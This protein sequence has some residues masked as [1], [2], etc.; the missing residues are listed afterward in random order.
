MTAQA[1]TVDVSIHRGGASINGAPL[2]TS[3]PASEF[4]AIFGTPDRI[5]DGSPTP[6][7]VGH[8]NNQFHYYDA[9]GVTLNEH[10]YTYQMQHAFHGE[11]NVG[12]LH[13]VIG[14][15]E[16]QLSDADLEFTA[17]LPGTWFTTIPSSVD[18]QTITVAVSTQGPK[19]KSGRSSKTKVITCVSLCLPHDPWDT[20]IRSPETVDALGLPCF[21]EMRPLK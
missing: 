16:R 4:H 7:P 6:A 5:I 21:H 12:G 8:R 2:G 1:A 13:I 10:H 20:A 14:T 3:G 17:Q 11:M 15:L 18:G 9:Q 19:L